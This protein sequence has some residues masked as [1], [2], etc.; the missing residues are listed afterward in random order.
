VF[1]QSSRKVPAVFVVTNVSAYDVE[2]F[3]DLASWTMPIYVFD[4]LN[5][6]FVETM[7]YV[8][9]EL[10]NA[11]CHTS[12]LEMWLVL[13]MKSLFPAVGDTLGHLH[14]ASK[15]WMEMN[16]DWYFWRPSTWTFW[17]AW[18]RWTAAC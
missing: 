11:L 13:R 6:F 4:V 15:H 16:Y 7:N 2:T 8:Q 14:G 12:D 18:R 10:P 17:N 5:L 3:S 1:P 9:K